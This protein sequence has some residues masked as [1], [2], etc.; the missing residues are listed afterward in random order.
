MIIYQLWKNKKNVVLAMI[1]KSVVFSLSLSLFFS[2]QS[3]L[4]IHKNLIGT[5]VKVFQKKNI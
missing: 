3:I 4:N 2:S 5:N 1:V